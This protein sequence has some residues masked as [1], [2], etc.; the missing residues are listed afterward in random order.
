MSVLLSR[1]QII[2]VRA[3]LKRAGKRVVFTNGVFDILHAGHVDY[4]VKAREFGDALIL[5]LNS[6]AVL[7]FIFRG[8]F[9][10][11]SINALRQSRAVR[12]RL[13]QV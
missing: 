2:K 5:G 1:E 8:Q 12:H 13:F 3:E 11:Q 9:S 4:L 10:S 7:I 6:D